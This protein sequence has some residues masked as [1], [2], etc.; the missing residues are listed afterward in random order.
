MCSQLDNSV[1][2]RAA[3][4]DPVSYKF[5]L[6]LVGVLPLARLSP[7]SHFYLC[8]SCTISTIE[9][10]GDNICEESSRMICE[11]TEANHYRSGRLVDP[12]FSF[13]S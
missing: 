3:S 10:T 2:M 11:Q 6:F 1:R 4:P 9:M 8:R 7:E 12:V 5:R 13:R